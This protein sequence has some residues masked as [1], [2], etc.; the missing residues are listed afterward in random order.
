MNNRLHSIF[1]KTSSRHG[2]A[3]GRAG[4]MSIHRSMANQ[5]RL[6]LSGY[7]SRSLL[8]S[9]A[10]QRQFEDSEGNLQ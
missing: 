3:H 2:I 8:S 10:Y 1:Y 6:P 4:N 7:Y 9:K 5:S